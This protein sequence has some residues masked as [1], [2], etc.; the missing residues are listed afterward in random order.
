MRA[1]ARAAGCAAL[2]P[3][4]PFPGTRWALDALPIEAGDATFAPAA[5]SARRAPVRPAAR[6]P[7]PARDAATA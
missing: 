6:L 1:V 5:G 4:P 7:L 2:P 3:C